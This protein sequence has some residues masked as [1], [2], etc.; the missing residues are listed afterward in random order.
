MPAFEAVYDR[1]ESF[2]RVGKCI[3]E[4]PLAGMPHRVKSA[5]GL[6]GAN[7]AEPTILTT[8]PPANEGSEGIPMKCMAREVLTL[9]AGRW[10]HCRKNKQKRT[11]P[12]A[13]PGALHLDPLENLLNLLLYTVQERDRRL[14]LPPELAKDVRRG[15]RVRAQ[16]WKSTRGCQ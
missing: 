1:L 6:S 11:R 4:F 5:R 15:P 16:D 7:I 12:Q 14:G 3:K 8:M 13:K 2:A 10:K 9:S